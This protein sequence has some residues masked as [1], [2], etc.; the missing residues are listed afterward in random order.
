MLPRTP[1]RGD[2]RKGRFARMDFRRRRRAHE[3]LHLHRD[4][5]RSSH[6]PLF[7]DGPHGVGAHDRGSGCRA[8][9]PAGG[10]GGM[11]KC[12]GPHAWTHRTH[13]LTRERRTEM[14][15]RYLAGEKAKV[16]AAEFNVHENYVRIAA[17][18]M[19][20]AQRGSVKT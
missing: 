18:R 9:T 16:L 2:A 20:K 7:E 17:R 5:G 14:V 4:P 8:A 12:H 3:R 15:N 19:D 11:S 1:L 6:R 10:G 13:T